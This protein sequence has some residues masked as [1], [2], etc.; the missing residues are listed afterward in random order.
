MADEARLFKNTKLA[1][2]TRIEL[3]YLLVR[4][5]VR[6]AQR[7]GGRRFLR[8][9][10]GTRASKSAIDVT[11]FSGDDTDE[12]DRS[13]REAFEAAGVLHRSMEE[14]GLSEVLVNPE[15]LEI[16]SVRSIVQRAR[17]RDRDGEVM[18]TLADA[19]NTIVRE[20]LLRYGVL[21]D[22]SWWED[23]FV[24]ASDEKRLLRGAPPK[25]LSAKTGIRQFVVSHKLARA[26][27][28]TTRMGPGRAAV[29]DE[30]PG[31]KRE[32]IQGPFRVIVTS[33]EA[34]SSRLVPIIV[35]DRSGDRWSI[36][37][38]LRALP[39]MSPRE[40]YVLFPDIVRKVVE[41]F[42]GSFGDAPVHF[43]TTVGEEPDIDRVFFDRRFVDQIFRAFIGLAE[44]SGTLLDTTGAGRPFEW[45]I[46]VSPAPSEEPYD[47]ELSEDV[48][49]L[50]RYLGSH[51]EAGRPTVDEFVVPRDALA[52]VVGFC[53]TRPEGASF[54]V[55]GGP[56]GV[57]HARSL[58]TETTMASANRCKEVFEIAR[59]LARDDGTVSTDVA[60]RIVR[61][62]LASRSLTDAR[63]MFAE[64]NL[65]GRGERVLRE[66]ATVVSF[67][68]A[69]G[70]SSKHA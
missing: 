62:T 29:S 20:C 65:R 17:K 24:S 23:R 16:E 50:A 64:S 67:A 61:E 53:G 27:V 11:S 39:S 36:W 59:S 51:R 49:E 21:R 38:R 4:A 37:L 7:H 68:R 26:A 22:E 56:N 14:K 10:R 3:L 41:R 15:T 33:H 18:P 43:N 19:R 58:L 31:W 52:T 9:Y 69:S 57:L 54:W 40:A 47:E 32:M 13:L 44:R 12:E 66:R 35:K 6:Q 60:A 30:P 70:R 46:D 5:R 34:R 48:G 1:D 45:T 63:K 42:R 25:V 2:V 55:L 28:R 8:L